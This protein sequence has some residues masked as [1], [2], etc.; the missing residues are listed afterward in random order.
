MF[1]VVDASLLKII[2]HDTCDIIA[3]RKVRTS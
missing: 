3:L 2:V 1:D